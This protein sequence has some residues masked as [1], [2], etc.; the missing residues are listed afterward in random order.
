MRAAGREGFL[1]GFLCKVRFEVVFF[2]L[3]GEVRS[4]VW[5]DFAWFFVS[6][7]GF[8]AGSS[9]GILRDFEASGIGHLWNVAGN[10]IISV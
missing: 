7:V 6:V 4:L 10:M 3:W 5:E 9:T 8:W 1:S 2:F